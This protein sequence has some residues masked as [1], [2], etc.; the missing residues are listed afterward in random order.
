MCRRHGIFSVFWATLVLAAVLFV[1]SVPA[2]NL[3]RTSYG[4]KHRASFGIK[5]GVLN[6]ATF[7]YDG[8]EL[9]TDYGIMVGVLFDFPVTSWFMLGATADILDIKAMDERHKALDVGFTMKFPIYRENRDFVI[10]PGLG[11]GYG[12]LAHVAQAFEASDYM[13]TKMFVEGVVYSKKRYAFL[14][15]L[16]VLYT[17]IGG[18][19]EFDEMRYGPAVYFR[20]GVI[21]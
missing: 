7:R 5:A 21:Y 1:S 4:K 16:G 13:T 20:I 18:S 14:L 2:E 6:A 19:S 15:D 17:P 12:Y 11:V 9:D 10:R 8:H 3:V